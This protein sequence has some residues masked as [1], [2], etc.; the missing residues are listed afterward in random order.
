MWN[1]IIK[2]CIR[3]YVLYIWTLLENKLKQVTGE[4]NVG[5]KLGWAFKVSKIEYKRDKG[6][7]FWKLSNIRQIFC[8]Q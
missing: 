3:D 7:F 2:Y 5:I 4:K 1:N 6:E 8:V